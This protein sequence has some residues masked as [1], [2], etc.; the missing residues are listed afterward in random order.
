MVIPTAVRMLHTTYLLIESWDFL[1]ST[2]PVVSSAYGVILCRKALDTTLCVADK[3]STFIITTS[4]FIALC[5]DTNNRKYTDVVDESRLVWGN[6][7]YG[8]CI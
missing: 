6:I 8:P 3:W 1:K 7:C 4:S 5:M 2:S